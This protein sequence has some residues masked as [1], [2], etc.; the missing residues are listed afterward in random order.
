MVDGVIGEGREPEVLALF[1]PYRLGQEVSAGFRL[2]NVTI[3]PRAIVVE[4]R[5]EEGVS[6]LIRLVP[7]DATARERSSSF[8]ILRQAGASNGD[9]AAAADALIVAL[10]KNDAGGFWRPPETG[11]RRHST[12][13]IPRE[14]ARGIA[15]P[16]G[17]TAVF[18]A[19]MFVIGR[20]QSLT[21]RPE[22]RSKTR[23]V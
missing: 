5:R 18:G 2:W 7:L 19:L 10:T 16:L 8:A 12:S 23:S 3:E 9:G 6:A 14:R 13:H 1:Q 4:L 22:T 20:R 17:L 15:W 11:V 21:S